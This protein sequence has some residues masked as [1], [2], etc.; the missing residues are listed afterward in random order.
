[1]ARNQGWLCSSRFYWVPYP[2]LD[3]VG[4]CDHTLSRHYE[5][6]TTGATIPCERYV[7]FMTQTNAV[8]GGLGGPAEERGARRQGTTCQD[9]HYWLPFPPIP[10]VGECDSPSSEHFRRPTFSDKPTERCF[11]VR[12][13]E[14]LEFMWCQ[15]HRQTIHSTELPEHWSCRVFISSASLPVEDQAELTLAGD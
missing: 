12:S 15:S 4:T 13:L 11:V 1:M 9:C 3:G 5:R 10:R 7:P 14:G 6:M 8:R 2:G